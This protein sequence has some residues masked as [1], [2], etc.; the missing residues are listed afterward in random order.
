MRNMV[1]TTVFGAIALTAAAPA[2]A[3]SWS[4]KVDLCAS[5]VE[6][7]ELANINEYDVQ[8]GNATSS[9]RLEIKLVPNAGGKT[10]IAEC[11]LRRGEVTAVALKA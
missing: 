8:F 3:N 7:N 9:R 5:A 1:L 11:R 4:E 2:S 10:L 6:A